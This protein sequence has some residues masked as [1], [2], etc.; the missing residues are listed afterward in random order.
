MATK[1]SR[2][3][4]VALR[5]TKPNAGVRDAY[6]KEL[7][8]LVREMAEDVAET[9]KK[10]Y[11]R[12][13]P[14]LAQDARLPSS[15]LADMMELLRKRWTKRFETASER[16]S[17]KFVQ[18][19]KTSVTN[20]KRSAIRSAGLPEAFALKFDRGLVSQDVLKAITQ[21]NTSLIKSIGSKY[22]D[23]V[24]G[25]VM[26]SVTAGRDVKGLAGELQRRY[27]VT[28]RRAVF[29]A[30][31]QN[32][33]ASE[34]LS[35][36]QDAQSGI[37]RG[38]WIHVPGRWTSRETHRHMDGKEFD[39]REGLYDSDAGRKILPGELPGCQC[40]YRPLFPSELWT[41]KR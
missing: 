16:I 22:L 40:T 1:A 17:K 8:A 21:E 4:K 11:D 18:G 3:R 2:S 41:P 31:D 29:I 33:K 9:L 26:R 19:V 20:Q 30:R 38:V 25:L 32:N 14:L 34:A 12:H 37:T 28:K 39:L 24:E 7:S 6:A 36:A 35:R 13:E 15:A 27:D 5:S 23:D 10:A